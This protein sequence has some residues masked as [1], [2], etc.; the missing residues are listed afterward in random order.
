MVWFCCA[1]VNGS[2][3]EEGGQHIE[4]AITGDIIVNI[5]TKAHTG[6]FQIIHW[7]DTSII[8]VNIYGK[9]YRT[10]YVHTGMHQIA[11]ES[12]PLKRDID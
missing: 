12:I 3:N 11:K 7:T 6:D 2:S 10:T 1:G 5:R 4:I 8:I 9:F